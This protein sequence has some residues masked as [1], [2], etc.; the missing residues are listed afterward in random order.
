MQR[1]FRLTSSHIEEQEAETQRLA[2]SPVAY[3]PPATNVY[4]RNML[5]LSLSS[6]FPCRCA[7]CIEPRK[8]IETMKMQAEPSE[9][10]SKTSTRILFWRTTATT[11]TTTTTT[12]TREHGWKKKKRKKMVWR[13]APE[14]ER[15][16]VRARESTRRS[17]PSQILF[18]RDENLPLAC[19]DSV[20]T[21]FSIGLS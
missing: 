19:D 14:W 9:F 5:S 16:G 3:A 1:L 13:E 18:K 15:P 6:L 7:H 11:T 10:N 17:T 12:T 2:Y 8:R 4:Y 21:F 20:A